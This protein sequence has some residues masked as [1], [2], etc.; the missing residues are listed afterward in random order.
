MSGDE[1]KW[2]EDDTLYHEMYTTSPLIRNLEIEHWD[3]VAILKERGRK[4]TVKCTALVSSRKKRENYSTYMKSIMGDG[5][6]KDGSLE[7]ILL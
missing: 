5:I 7:N 4:I 1:G 3:G 2:S 6:L